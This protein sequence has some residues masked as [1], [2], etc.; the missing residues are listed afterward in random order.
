MSNKNITAE[1]LKSCKDLATRIESIA[2]EL[3]MLKVNSV[4]LEH[5]LDKTLASIKSLSNE[6][7]TLFD[8]ESSIM[9]MFMKKYGTTNIDWE[10]GTIN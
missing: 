3:G 4:K 8:K 9:E 1:E 7:T 5:D 6:L 10:T 2:A